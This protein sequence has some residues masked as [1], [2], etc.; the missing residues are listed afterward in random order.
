M[1]KALI[2]GFIASLITFAGDMLLGY[3]Q[4]ENPEKSLMNFSLSLPLP[5]IL[6]GGFLG[7][8]GIPLQCIGYWQIYKLM[9]DGSKTLSKLYKVGILGW[10][11]M[12]TCG[13]HLNCA[14]V[15]LIYK[16]LYTTDATLAHN[17]ATTFADSILVP[18]YYIFI[19]FFLLMNITQFL[20]F[21]RKKTVY[22]RV[23][24]LC[25]MLIGIAVI[26]FIAYL[27]PDSAIKNGLNVSAI[28]LG[29][30]LMFIGLLLSNPSHSSDQSNN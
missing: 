12:A 25:N 3:I 4:V 30:A 28:S 23:V 20:A 15:M 17:V 26:Y 16:Q 5:R 8:I 29:N 21:V 27:L 1:K 2:L 10:L 6:W 19:V 9:K 24:A 7:V 18:C 13:V 11:T 14:V 22:P